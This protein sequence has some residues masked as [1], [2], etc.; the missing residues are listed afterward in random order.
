MQG[1]LLAFGILESNVYEL[2]DPAPDAEIF[3][4]ALEPGSKIVLPDVV[5]QRLGVQEKSKLVLTLQPD[6][7]VVM[8]SLRRVV[9][10]AR[11]QLVRERRAREGRESSE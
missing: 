6:G 10:E 1:T 11:D 7:T 8:V 3:T 4:V 5:R 9:D 2:D